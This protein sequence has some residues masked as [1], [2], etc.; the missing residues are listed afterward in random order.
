MSPQ[1]PS[2]SRTS[3]F[4]TAQ[5]RG[6]SRASACSI[7]WHLFPLKLFSPPWHLKEGVSSVQ[8][9][10]MQLDPHESCSEGEGS[11]VAFGSPKLC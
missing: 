11:T 5:G 2:P 10:S 1:C 4:T 6:F 9:H 7:W 8:C 3:S